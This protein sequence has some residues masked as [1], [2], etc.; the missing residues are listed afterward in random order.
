MYWF[1]T[2]ELASTR[3]HALHV[4]ACHDQQVRTARENR[5]TSRRH[6]LLRARRT[7]G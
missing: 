4:E 3:I 5:V 1:A 6:R 7:H 2:D